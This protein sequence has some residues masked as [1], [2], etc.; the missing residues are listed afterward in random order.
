MS[1]MADR[2]ESGGHPVTRMGGIWNSRGVPIFGSVGGER[3]LL[4]RVGGWRGS[5]RTGRGGARRGRLLFHDAHRDDRALIEGEQR[6][7][8][9]GLAQDIRR[10]QHS[11]DD[12]GNDDEVAA[13][14][15]Q[16]LRR[17]D[18]D[19]PEQGQDHRKLERD[20]EGKDQRHHQRQI[21]AHLGQQ[22][23]LRATPA[24]H[25]LHPQ[26]EADQHRK[27]D[28][29]DQQRSEQ[30]E[31]RGSDQV[32]EERLALVR[33]KS[34]RDELVDLGCHDRKRDE[35]GAEQRKLQLRNEIFQKCCVN[36]LRVLSARHPDKGPDQ[37]VVDLLGEEEA[38]DEGDAEA[39]QRLDQARAQLDQMIKKRRLAG[40]DVG[41]G[42]DAL[43]SFKSAGA[44]AAL[45][46]GGDGDGAS[47]VIANGSVVPLSTAGASGAAAAGGAIASFGL[48]T[49]SILSAL[50][51]SFSSEVMMLPL[52]KPLAASLTSSKL[53]LRSAI[54]A[55]RIASWNW[56]WNSA[57]ILR[58]LPIHCPS[59]R[60]TPGSSFGPM[61][62]SATTAM[63]TNSLQPMSN[64]KD[65][66]QAGPPLPSP[67]SGSPASPSAL[68][69][70]ALLP[71]S[72]RVDVVDD[73]ELCSMD[74]AGSDLSS[75]A[76]SSS[77]MPFLKALIPWATSPIRSEILPRP[78]NSRTTA[79]TTI[80]CQILSEPNLQP[81]KAAGSPAHFLAGK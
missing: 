78:N 58:A 51:T 53:F 40:L 37:H 67:A 74:F 47:A 59:A 64:M 56:L 43:A 48:S 39:E 63:R 15:A 2:P 21:F 33:V 38:E 1:C 81:S 44:S 35:A 46:C 80:Q 65:S 7:G 60:S 20:A 54:S 6:Q 5:G 24:A 76:V 10:G 66:A 41:I 61:A 32:R 77:R 49:S 3:R 75:A 14:L 62:I 11:S 13:L 79:I 12:E 30:E 73:A 4:G 34:R 27:D 70:T 31:D 45:T 36:E 9:R 17:D 69:Q 71:T 52:P 57:A 28:E 29:I 26:R 23:D 25:L 16:H 55:S 18:A 50:D 42:H 19:T 72:D 22:L 8:Q 68:V